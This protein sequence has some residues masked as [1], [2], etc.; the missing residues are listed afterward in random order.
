MK[1]TAL[2]QVKQASESCRELFSGGL[3]VGDLVRWK[4]SPL[5]NL[6]TYGL[7]LGFNKVGLPIIYWMWLNNQN[8]YCTTIRTEAESTI[9]RKRF[10]KV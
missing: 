8:R 3:Q 9:E 10:F 7:V 5:S 4:D 6:R 2:D 1:P